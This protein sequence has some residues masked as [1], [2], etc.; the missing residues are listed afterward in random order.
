M[1][2][3]NELHERQLI[4]AEYRAGFSNEQAHAKLGPNVS[5]E[6]IDNF[7]RRFKAGK[8]SLF[9]E[10]TFQHRIVQAI[11]TMPNGDEVRKYQNL[12]N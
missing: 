9:D 6:T 2:N 8:I 3:R 10:R 4:W 1:A 7:Y 5:R 12:D 11:Q